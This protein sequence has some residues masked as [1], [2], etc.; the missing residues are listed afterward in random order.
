MAGVVVVLQPM[1]FLGT[2]ADLGRCPRIT[3]RLDAVA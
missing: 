2:V 1:D 3:I